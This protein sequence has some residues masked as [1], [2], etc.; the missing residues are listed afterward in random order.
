MSQESEKAAI[1]RWLDKRE[2]NKPPRFGQIVTPR[3]WARAHPGEPYPQ[4]R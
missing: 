4:R 3:D 2:K 1:K